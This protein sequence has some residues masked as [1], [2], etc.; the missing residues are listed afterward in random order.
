MAPLRSLVLVLLFSVA[1][2]AAEL[3]NK[4]FPDDFMFGAATSAYQIEGAW[5]E[6]GKGENIW[7]HITHRNKTF[8]HGGDNGDI[9]SDSYHKYKEDVAILKAMNVTHYRFSIGWSRILPNGFTN[10]INDLGVAYYNNLINELKSNNIEPLVT[11]YHWDT[12]QAIQDIG[13]FPNGIIVDLFADYAE[14]C[15]KLFGDRVKYWMTFNEP[16]QPCN[17][18]YGSGDYAPGIQSPGIG[19]YMCSHN[20]IK[21]H[22]KAW[23]IY[24]DKFRA[25]QKGQ[26]G[27]VIDSNWWEPASDSAEDKEA[28]ETKLHFTF[29]LY[30]N[31]IFNGDYPKVM[32]D[33]I[34]ERSLA[35][36][37]K[38]SRL[39]P[40]TEKEIAEIKGTADFLGVNTYSSSLVSHD[41]EVDKM[42]M[43][44]VKDSEVKDWF[45]DSWEKGASDWLTVTPWGSRKLLKWIKDTYNSPRI[46]ITENGYSDFDGTLDDDKRIH[47]IS[48]YLSSIKDAMDEDGVDIFGYT[49]WSLL[50]NLEWTFGFTNKFGLYNVD[51]NSPNRTRTPK[52]SATFYK[53]LIKTKCLVDK[54]VEK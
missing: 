26:V 36:G 12:P 37:F 25:E 35:Q 18:G 7:D 33:K 47:Y 8:T 46:I 31:P 45:D 22:A 5:N 3:N 30:A 23:H 32:K 39:P 41:K 16:K 1:S 43:G 17:H 11:L 21:A 28:S 29:G 6:D 49:V 27:I 4:Y 54:C 15:F 51:F 50:D 38:E 19:E 14:L 10:Q 13:G 48:T 2:F 44:Y 9:T 20:V 34:K 52:K 42:A 53:N 40:F 24:N